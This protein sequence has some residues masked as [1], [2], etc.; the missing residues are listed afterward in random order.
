MKGR[1]LPALLGV[2]VAGGVLGP[3]LMLVGIDRVSAV[4]GSLRLNLEGPLTM[5]LAVT[6][7]R[8]HLGRAGL[9]AAISILSGAALLRLQTAGGRADAW[10]MAAIAL[11][12]LA[13][14]V[15]NNL[16][17]RLSLRD[18]FAVVRI[19]AL[20]AGSFNLGLGLLLGGRLLARG[21]NVGI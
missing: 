19:K 11:A 17:Q 7:F 15:D 21:Q 4:V 18:P 14:A 10:G 2:I 1:D 9:F 8:E 5:L 20:A 16:T 3:L 12:C 13:W 6:F